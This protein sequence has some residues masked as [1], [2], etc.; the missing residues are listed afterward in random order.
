M[1]YEDRSRADS[2]AGVTCYVDLTGFLHRLAYMPGPHGINPQQVTSKVTG[3][4]TW[5]IVGTFNQLNT[6]AKQGPARVIAFA[7]SSQDGF[8]AEL[9]PGYKRKSGSPYLGRQL[10]AWL[11]AFRI[12]GS[13]S[14]GP[15][16]RFQAWRP[17]T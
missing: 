11:N 9:L 10:S 2:A 6:L 17:R 1:E 14:S 13:L 16:M 12:W 5:G 4:P 7:D 3:E 15:T 8:R